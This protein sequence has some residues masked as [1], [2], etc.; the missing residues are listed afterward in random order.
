MAAVTPLT[1][2][3]KGSLPML[4]HWNQQSRM[5]DMQG[6]VD[7]LIS[8]LHQEKTHYAPCMDYISAIAGASRPSSPTDSTSCGSSLGCTSSSDRV[9][10][11]WRRKLCEWCFEVVDH[12]GMER[13]VVSVAMNYL[14]RIVAK[15][16]MTQGGEYHMAKRQYQLCAVS[17]LYIA[18][19]LHGETEEVEM[20]RKRLNVDVFVELSRGFF[21]AETLEAME[22]S[23]LFNLDWHLNPPTPL[24]FIASLLRLIPSW[25]SS[26]FRGHPAFKTVFKAIFDISMYLTE[27]SVC[28][29]TFTFHSKNSIVAYAS[30]LCAMEALEDS[31]PLPYDVRVRFLNNVAQATGLLPESEKVRCVRNLLMELCPCIEER[32]VASLIMMGEPEE[33]DAGKASPV[34]VSHPVPEEFACRKRGRD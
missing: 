3:E 29:S 26:E 28:V 9:N 25:S 12:F 19:K 22:L 14:D 2:D 17:S 10:E 11:A 33:E 34:C 24:K 20:D 32:D 6:T 31:L 18:I 13:E 5:Q 15:T 4:D 23:I 27:L 8:L 7:H 1:P 21:Q 16:L 30:I